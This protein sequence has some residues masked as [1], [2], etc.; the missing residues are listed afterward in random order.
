MIKISKFYQIRITRS[1]FQKLYRCILRELSSLRA[2]PAGSSI[3]KESVENVS[4]EISGNG[5]GEIK[6]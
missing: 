2:N 1:I 3:T 4:T 5:G 6:G